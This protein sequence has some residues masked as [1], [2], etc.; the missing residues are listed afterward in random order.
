MQTTFHQNHPVPDPHAQTGPE[1]TVRLNTDAS[2]FPYSRASGLHLC[3]CVCRRKL[4]PLSRKVERREKRKEVSEADQLF[5]CVCV[6]V[7]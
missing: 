7:S 5:L 3:V 6:C 2:H 1:E 4:V